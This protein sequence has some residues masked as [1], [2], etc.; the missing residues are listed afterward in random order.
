MWQTDCLDHAVIPQVN[1]FLWIYKNWK[2]YI[3]IFISLPYS[4]L[5]DRFI[6]S[7][8]NKNPS[9]FVPKVQITFSTDHTLMNSTLTKHLWHHYNFEH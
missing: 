7:C 3:T 1:V 6:V 2:Q 5:F 8:Q 4:E 9:T